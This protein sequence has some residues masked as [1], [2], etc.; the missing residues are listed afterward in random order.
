MSKYLESHIKDLQGKTCL[1][2]GSGTGL[3]SIVA[4]LLGA[5][6]VLATDLAGPHTEH[7][8]RNT[9]TNALRIALE[10]QQAIQEEAGAAAPETRHGASFLRRRRDRLKTTELKS[11][12]LQVAP[13]DWGSPT[14]PES[15]TF[16]GP[17]SY[18]LCSEILYLPQFHR[19]LLKTITQFSDEQ[20]VVVLLWK[21]R[22][23][24][25]ERFF[26]IASRPS[27]GWHVEFLDKSVLDVEFQEQP[28]G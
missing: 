17:F 7:V 6:N 23:L 12:N 10:R 22:G 14:L 11:E 18:I 21:Q 28:Y 1:E 16:Q 26:E 15:V 9:S 2:L 19:A 5:E 8:A 24:G 27:T 13:L 3:V 20:T 4:W 25:E